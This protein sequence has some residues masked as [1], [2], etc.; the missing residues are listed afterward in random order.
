L[1]LLSVL[2]PLVLVRALLLLSVLLPLVLVRA[3][4]LL[5]VL[6]PLALVRPLLLLGVLLLLFG[7]PLWLSMLLLGPGLFVIGLL[8]LALWF[9]RMVLLLFVVL[10]MLREGRSRDSKQ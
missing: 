5:S 8:G 6:L 10:L 1:L 7:L 4:L 2:L 9:L 3:L